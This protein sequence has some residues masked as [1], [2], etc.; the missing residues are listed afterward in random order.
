MLSGH[1][2][3]KIRLIFA[4]TC[5]VLGFAFD[6]ASGAGFDDLTW[7]LLETRHAII[8]YQT[9]DDLKDYCKPEAPGTHEEICWR[10]FRKL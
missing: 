8:R 4:G 3:T 10:G 9:L 7:K 5:L 6:M 2:T 1:V